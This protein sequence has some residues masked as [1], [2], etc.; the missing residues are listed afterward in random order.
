VAEQI[1]GEL[2]EL[3]LR[4]ARPHQVATALTRFAPADGPAVVILED[5]H[6]ADDAS[7]DVLQMLARPLRQRAL[8]VLASQRND[9]VERCSALQTAL[10]DLCGPETS[11]LD[12]PALS[13]QG[14]KA[15]SRGTGRDALQLH[16]LT[17]GNAFHVTEVLAAPE[18]DVPSTVVDATLSRLS[19]I[20]DEARAVAEAVAVVP[21]RAEL[22]LVEALAGAE[23]LDEAVAAGLL[24]AAA[25]GVTFRHELAR[26]AVEGTLPPYRRVVLHRAAL[27]A[28]TA[29]PGSEPARLAHHADAAQDSASV[30][31]HARAA[32]ERAARVGAKREAAAHWQ[33]A[34]RHAP[35]DE[36]LLRADL[37]EEVSYAVYVVDR[38]A[39]S[40]TA[41]EEALE[42]RREHGDRMGEGRV[43]NAL[44][45]RVSCA[46]R[47]DE[48]PALTDA[49][50]RVLEE[51]PP[52]AEL[53]KVY[54]SRC[55]AAFE[56]A[57]VETAQEW[58]RRAVELAE[59]LGDVDVAVHALNTLGTLE[60]VQ[61]RDPDLLLRSLKMAEEHNPDEA[62]GR[63]LLHLTSA[64]AEQ[65]RVD[66]L[67]LFE[68]AVDDCD[69]RG[70]ELW[71][72]YVVVNRAQLHLHL[73]RWDEAVEGV[74]EIMASPLRAQLLRLGAACVT[75]KVRLRQGD[76]GGREALAQARALA[77]G[78]TGLDWQRPLTL[79]EAEMAWLESVPAED[80]VALT[81]GVLTDCEQHQEHWA[82]DE[83]LRWRRLSGARPEP[84]TGRTLYS[85]PSLDHWRKLGCGFDA[86]LDLLELGEPVEALALLQMIGAAGTAARVAKDLRQRGVHDLPRGPRPSTRANPAGLTDRELNVLLLLAEGRSNSAIADV[87]VLSVKT[88]DKHVSAALRKFDVRS[89]AEASTRAHELGVSVGVGVG[90]G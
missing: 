73:G 64:F 40:V 88:V 36:P 10:G 77:D 46:G 62:V 47:E 43:L 59:Q 63:A 15:L 69:R 26:R 21:Q 82:V 17:G 48:S 83:L 85:Q 90:V 12:V 50:H 41:L 53:A 28:L 86:A 29:R 32:A 1:G 56:E 87:L 57:D 71:R 68:D 75:A 76:P 81:A 22:W 54:A 72:R 51:L 66:Q 44:T 65:H 34:L 35:A 89:R 38:M 7:L 23:H 42:I 24:V 3:V 79:V 58:G 16:R 61:G 4:E 11:R 2:A 18:G 52:S 84:T 5:L 6:W 9:E 33:Q 27:A 8:L 55:F 80:V 67:P 14:V 13:P 74:A 20:S 39:E 37:L 31:V 30:L 25:D 70:L 49:A 60:L 45:R 78:H 19:R